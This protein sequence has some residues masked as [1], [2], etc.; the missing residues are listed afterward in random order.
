MQQIEAVYYCP[1]LNEVWRK[2]CKSNIAGGIV[3]LAILI[4]V[5]SVVALPV[6]RAEYLNRRRRQ[7]IGPSPW[8][9]PP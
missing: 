4:L 6:A 3:A 2:R 8:S 9:N 5:Q 7:L 1:T